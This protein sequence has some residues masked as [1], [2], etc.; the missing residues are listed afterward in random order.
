MP[1]HTQV[2]VA[3]ATLFLN[4]RLFLLLRTT[5]RACAA[6]LDDVLRLTHQRNLRPRCEGQTKDQQEEHQ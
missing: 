6:T 3:K 4:A 2:Q 5:H 1:S